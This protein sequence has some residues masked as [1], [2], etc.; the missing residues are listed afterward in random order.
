M[1][2]VTLCQEAA[3]LESSFYHYGTC[4]CEGCLL[5]HTYSTTYFS[6]FLTPTVIS[7]GV[8]NA[9]SFWVRA[10]WLSTGWCEHYWLLAIKTVIFIMTK[11]TCVRRLSLTKTLLKDKVNEAEDLQETLKLW[12]IRC[13]STNW[14]WPSQS[15]HQV[16]SLTALVGCFGFWFG[17]VLAF[18]NCM[19][20]WVSTLF[21]FSQKCPVTSKVKT[22]WHSDAN[23]VS[24]YKYESVYHNALL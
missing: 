10:H 7:S 1:S 23:S 16:T 17:F 4:C 18:S 22:T 24:L 3:P 14:T 8:V 2:G 5:R 9:S 21:S 11:Y 15:D 19:V 6:T 20:L 13:C 12:M